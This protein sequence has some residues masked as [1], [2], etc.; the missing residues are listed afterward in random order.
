MSAI[1]IVC[2]V[3]AVMIFASGMQMKQI[4]IAAPP[5][6]LVRNI[7]FIARRI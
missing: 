3:S 2:M 5:I 6:L 1:G 7:L 4:I